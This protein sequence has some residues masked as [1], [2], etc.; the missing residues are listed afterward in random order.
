MKNV[1]TGVSHF[2]KSFISGVLSIVVTYFCIDPHNSP[3]KAR[4]TRELK[5]SSANVSCRW[6]L[7]FKNKRADGLN[8]QRPASVSG[9]QA[10]R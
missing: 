5:R 2:S 7:D 9:D 6:C 8:G 10:L 4:W 1:P 3:F